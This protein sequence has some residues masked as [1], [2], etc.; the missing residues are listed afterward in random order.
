M[1][2]P[3]SARSRSDSGQPARPRTERG[4]DAASERFETVKTVETFG[5][6]EHS[7]VN[8]RKQSSR[9]VP[10]CVA[11]A[12]VGLMCVGMAVPAAL[13]R[14][15][16][17]EEFAA[18]HQK[19][20][21]ECEK[22][23]A[24]LRTEKDDAK[25][26]LA[27]AQ[28]THQSQLIAVSNAYTSALAELNALR[29]SRSGLQHA[30]GRPTPALV[31][32]GVRPAIYESPRVEHKSAKPVLDPVK[33][34]P[35]PRPL[36]DSP[37]EVRT[38]NRSNSEKAGPV[39]DRTP[40]LQGIVFAHDGV[41]WF[42]KSDGSWHFHSGGKWHRVRAPKITSAAAAVAALKSN[43]SGERHSAGF[44]G[45]TAEAMSSAGGGVQSQAIGGPVRTGQR[46]CDKCDRPVQLCG[47]P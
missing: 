18:V 35:T 44:R 23:L 24:G 41:W 19:S 7:E 28:F 31:D 21:A 6:S 10:V 4:K 27:R 46:C 34:A 26:E 22:E 5:R 11:A 33:N 1:A 16:S 43:A 9:L 38:A 45:V 15:S 13:F 39:A 8:A 20:L 12:I 3:A 29:V 32:D 25:A 2:N 37:D 14:A 42:Q 47:C 40:L 36:S 17:A 30:N